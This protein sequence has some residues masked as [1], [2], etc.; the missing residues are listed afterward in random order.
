MGLLAAKAAEQRSKYIVDK[1]HYGIECST[2]SYDYEYYAKL[3]FIS[4]CEDVCTDDVES[5]SIDSTLD[6]SG[7]TP[8]FIEI[9]DC[10]PAT[11]IQDCNQVF[12]TREIQAPETNTFLYSTVV[13]VGDSV[14]LEFDSVTVNAVSYLNLTRYVDITPD[15]VT[16]ETVGSITYVTNIVTFLNSLNL[17]GITFSP[18]TTNRTMRV[19][20]PSGTTFEISG[21][22]NG[23]LDETSHGA[24]INQDGLVDLQL[25]VGAG[26][27]T[28]PIGGSIGDQWQAGYTQI[29]SE[30]L[31]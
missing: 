10:V 28:P 20:Y 21:V 11:K 25:T 4:D 5:L 2:C 8:V 3:D 14:R 29:S 7:R 18:G 26:V 6:C 22:A 19:Q 9:P 23:D 30:T 16:T 24:T 13:T 15:T 27:V 31:C 12:I 17:P 1:Y